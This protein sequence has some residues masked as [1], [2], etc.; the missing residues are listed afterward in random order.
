M[1]FRFASV[2]VTRVCLQVLEFNADWDKVAAGLR[3]EERAPEARPQKSASECLLRFVQMSSTSLFA[4][5]LERANGAVGSATGGGAAAAAGGG[6]A[7]GGGVA[8]PGMMVVEA[9]LGVAPA[10]IAATYAQH[11]SQPLP[12]SVQ[13]L[14]LLAQETGRAALARVGLQQATEITRALQSADGVSFVC[15]CV[16]VYEA[17]R[18][19]VG[20]IS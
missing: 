15:V 11:S 10:A 12:L 7:V 5:D 16:R 14:R 4:K 17:V 1:L 18:A 6:A 20:W 9:T 2:D 19:R 13:R 8:S 3:A